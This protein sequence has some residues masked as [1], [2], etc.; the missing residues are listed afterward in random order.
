NGPTLPLLGRET[1]IE[2]ISKET[3]V[4]KAL[5]DPE[6]FVVEIDNSRLS[7]ARAIGRLA[8]VDLSKYKKVLEHE[9]FAEDLWIEIILDHLWKIFEG[10]VVDGVEFRSIEWIRTTLHIGSVESAFDKWIKLT[11][12]AYEM[13]SD[14]RPVLLL[15]E[16]GVFMG[17][18]HRPS[19]TKKANGNFLMHTYLSDA[20]TT[21]LNRCYVIAS[22][23]R[24]GNLFALTADYSKFVTTNISLTPFSMED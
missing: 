17:M 13:T 22:G 7:A 24:D 4:L 10:C 15:D 2:A 3:T 16:I 11:N 14:A 12:A 6:G 20:I 18:T 19:S 1:Q 5:V 23:T 21:L 9:N 8:V